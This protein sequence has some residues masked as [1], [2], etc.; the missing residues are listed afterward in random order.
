[1]ERAG[2]EADW[3]DLIGEGAMAVVCRGRLDG[4]EVALKKLK[5]S[6]HSKQGWLE[7]FERE[8]KLSCECQN[9]NMVQVIGYDE[10][11]R[12]LCMGLYWLTWRIT[13]FAE[14]EF[15]SLD[16]YIHWHLET[17]KEDILMDCVLSILKDISCGMAYLNGKDIMHRDMHPG[18][19]LMSRDFVVKVC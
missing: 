10:T 2:V 15:V 1:M 8:A 5:E 7:C 3:Q 6:F 12:V 19:F 11:E 17:L 18:N 9:E 14:L 13:N 4:R 16:K